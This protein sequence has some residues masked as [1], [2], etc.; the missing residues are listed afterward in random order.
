MKKIVST[1]LAI[2]AMIAVNA[3]G[4]GDHG[5][6]FRTCAAI[7]VMLAMMVFVLAVLKGI[8]EHRLKNKIVDKGINENIA[9]SILQT[10]PKEGIHSNI[11]WFVLLTA[12]GIGLLIINSTLP[13]G[14][15]S[16]AIMAFSIGF[17]FLVYYVFISRIG[18]K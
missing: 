2:H 8:F 14:F 4:F 12:M 9:S 13:L 1:V 15:H 7:F 16:L 18:K 5:E 3:Q 17:S 11:K 10:T 6:I